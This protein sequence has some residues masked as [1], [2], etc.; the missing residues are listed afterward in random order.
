MPAKHR[1]ALA[2]FRCGVAPLRIE[3]GRYERLNVNQKIC[4]I[5]NAS[6]ED[7][8]H[9]LFTCPF[10]S[11]LRSALFMKADEVNSNFRNLS[12]THMLEFLFSTIDMV[13][14]LAKT[15]FL[16]LQRRSQFMS[17]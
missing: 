9:V 15:C 7:E 14:I 17:K 1:R 13:R 6:I 4:P 10:Y 3:T 16:I 8:R 11:D 12:E 2:K 5:C